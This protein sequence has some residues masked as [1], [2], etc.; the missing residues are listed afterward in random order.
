M[1]GISSGTFV[2]MQIFILDMILSLLVQAARM[3]I[4]ILSFLV[5]MFIAL[6]QAGSASPAA[7][8]ERSA[9]SP[10]IVIG[11]VGGFISHDNLIHGGVQLAAHL[12]KDYP[13]GVHVRVFEN[14]RG[15]DAHS[16]ILKI[17]DTHHSGKLS[18]EDK[19]SARIILYGHSWGGSEV[20]T[21]ARRLQGEGIPV[22]LTIQVDS[23]SKFGEDDSLIPPNVA[24][25]ANF[26]QL[27]GYLHGRPEI[28]AADP[29]RTQIIGNFRF[30]Y[31]SNPVRCSGYPWYARTFEKAHIE[32]ECDPNVLSRIDYLI[33]SKLPS[34]APSGAAR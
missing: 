5:A 12:R 14:H 15:E 9:M 21:L 30:D 16:E 20:V 3:S 26:Y 1:H 17:L 27:D 32:I 29:S 19:Q 8:G 6:G 18:P 24:Q 25:A 13:T 31:A 10:V 34:P 4:E 23:V 2:F 28:H 7:A 22:L 11:F 33:R